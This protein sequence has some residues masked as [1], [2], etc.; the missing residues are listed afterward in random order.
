MATRSTGP[1]RWIR[2]G[3]AAGGI[4]LVGL[5]GAPLFVAAAPAALFF[6]EARAFVERFNQWRQDRKDHRTAQ[7]TR[8]GEVLT[9]AAEYWVDELDSISN[10]RRVGGRLRRQLQSIANDDNLSSEEL[11]KRLQDVIPDSLAAYNE[12]QAEVAAEAGEGPLP[13]SLDE[14]ITADGRVNDRAVDQLMRHMRRLD[15][16][17][18]GLEDIGI[19]NLELLGLDADGEFLP[20]EKIPL[21]P[22]TGKGYSNQQIL[23]M[24]QE[25][26]VNILQRTEAL[27]DRFT[28]SYVPEPRATRTE[29]LSDAISDALL[30]TRAERRADRR[31]NRRKAARD[32]LDT[33]ADRGA[34]TVRQMRENA[35]RALDTEIGDDS[36]TAATNVRERIAELRV[37]GARIGAQQDAVRADLDDARSRV[38]AASD[39]YEALDPA[40]RAQ[41]EAANGS[42]ETA[43]Q[44]VVEAEQQLDQLRSLPDLSFITD[45]T[46]RK[47]ATAALLNA[48]QDA[49]ARQE[50]EIANRQAQVDRIERHI[51]TSPAHAVV[52]E[53]TRAEGDV[54]RLTAEQAR[55]GRE[56]FHNTSQ[57]GT[58]NQ[59]AAA[60]NV[61]GRRLARAADGLRGLS[62][63]SHAKAE[64]RSRTAGSRVT[65]RHLERRAPTGRGRRP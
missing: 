4:G 60:A 32:V 55:L 24:L 25:N 8:E 15:A 34:S 63:K 41:Y 23:H 18:Y 7:T 29:N 21:D 38:T 44:R 16:Q 33:L 42:R 49:I 51:E 22:A 37:E 6:P 61:R 3:V 45:E 59:R 10:Q 57:L 65:D 36:L 20:D 50:A 52:N 2:R 46:E 12:V 13:V 27:Q 5:L 14:L 1:G 54:A 39:A 53:R 62:D 19:R 58:L 43:A 31:E 48:R 26:D 30:P 47:A 35:T 56:R 17:L 40:V 9:Q 28:T 64:A 11:A